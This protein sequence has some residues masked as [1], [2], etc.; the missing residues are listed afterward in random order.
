MSRRS[1][2]KNDMPEVWFLGEDVN[3]GHKFGV[4]LVKDSKLGVSNTPEIAAAAWK[5]RNATNSLISDDVPLPDGF[6]APRLALPAS[7][8]A[9]DLIVFGS[10]DFVSRR[11]RDALA[12]PPEV[13]QFTPVDL[14]A[15]GAEARAQDYR[16]MRVLARQ[17]AMDL[18]RPDCILE[19][20]VNRITGETYQ[21]PRFI[22]RFV[23]LKDLRPRTEI[24]RLD[25]S[26]SYIL[27]TDTLAERILRAG[28]TGV[29]FAHPDNE[30]FTKTILRFRTING[31]KERRF[32]F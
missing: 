13:I 25:E 20:A 22:T 30:R 17:K 27:V 18:E 11:F 16:L 15:G 21:D 23:L 4:L 3:T 19:P 28:C 24:F 6:P 10:L 12:Q 14:V 1:A 9:P 31:M 7:G 26:S 8:F 2:P 32:G 5:L 29:E